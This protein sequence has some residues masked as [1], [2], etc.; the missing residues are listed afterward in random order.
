MMDSNK[1]KGLIYACQNYQPYIK[2]H[3]R[4]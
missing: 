3:V 1:G 4:W 2:T